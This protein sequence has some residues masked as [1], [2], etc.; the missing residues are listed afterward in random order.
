[1]SNFKSKF[2]VHDEF[3]NVKDKRF[4]HFIFGP[5]GWFF[6]T[7]YQNT[8]NQVYFHPKNLNEK[9]LYFDRIFS[10]VKKLFSTFLQSSF[11]QIR[12]FWSCQRV[13]KAFSNV[14]DVSFLGE[15]FTG[16]GYLNAVPS[17]LFYCSINM[18]DW[19]LK[20]SRFWD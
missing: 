16:W 5:I 4:F 19:V 20:L 13:F 6:I 12:S 8:S 14:D 1:M 7:A 9:R 2:I 17:L 3:E 11:V 10:Q 15:T 18:Q